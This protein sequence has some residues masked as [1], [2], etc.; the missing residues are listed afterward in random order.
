MYFHSSI[1]QLFRLAAVPSEVHCCAVFCLLCCSD[2]VCL[3]AFLSNNLPPLLGNWNFTVNNSAH[4]ASTI[5]SEKIHENMILAVLRS[6]VAVYPRTY[7]GTLTS[8]ATE[9]GDNSSDHGPLEFRISMYFQHNGPIYK[10]RDG[11]IMGNLVSSVIA[12]VY[13]EI[14]EEQPIAPCKPKTSK[15]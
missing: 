6:R 8:L 14:F 10:Q 13:M 7:Q 11:T 2:P 3:H 4:F 1:D 9:T 5:A 12:N 15:S